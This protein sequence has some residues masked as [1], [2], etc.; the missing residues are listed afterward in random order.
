MRRWKKKE[1]KTNKHFLFARK[2]H[3]NEN[4][5]ETGEEEKNYGHKIF[6]S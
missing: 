3:E 4:E 1:M 5:N 6:F 2:W